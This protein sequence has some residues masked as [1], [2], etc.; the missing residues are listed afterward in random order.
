MNSVGTVWCCPPPV[1]GSF[2]KCWSANEGSDRLIDAVFDIEA[3]F[4]LPVWIERVPS[5]S[6]PADVLSR[7]VVTAFGSAEKVEVDPCKMWRLVA[8]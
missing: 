7:E 5:Q 1:R 8:K 6:N 4:D 3:G 2:L